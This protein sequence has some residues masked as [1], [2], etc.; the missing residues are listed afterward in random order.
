M[1]ARPP[2]RTANARD[3]RQALLQFHVVRNRTQWTQERRGALSE[4]SATAARGA[5]RGQPIHVVRP[6]LS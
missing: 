5:C 4:Q 3:N 2:G 6:V 1:L